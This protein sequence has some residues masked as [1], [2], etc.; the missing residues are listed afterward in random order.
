M[1]KPNRRDTAFDI[2]SIMEAR[3][4]ILEAALQR[5]ETV[6]EPG[7]IRRAAVRLATIL[8]AH[9]EFE[10]DPS[11]FFVEVQHLGTGPNQ[12][13]TLLRNEHGPILQALTELAQAA[14]LSAAELR[15][16]VLQVIGQIRDHEA[17]EA[18][19]FF[20]GIYTDHGNQG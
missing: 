18:Q 15:P 20:D 17:R 6:C 16:K 12:K 1:S 8:H 3:F 7:A 4:T 14:G 2:D 5:F 11:T 10:E 9:Y 13:L 19:A